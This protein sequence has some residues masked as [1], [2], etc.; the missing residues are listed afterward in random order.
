M[1]TAIARA[2]ERRA[3]L[4]RGGQRGALEV[5]GAGRHEIRQAADEISVVGRQRGFDDVD[6][7]GEVRGQHLHRDLPPTRR[8]LAQVDVR[9]GKAE[10][11]D[12]QIVIGLVEPTHDHEAWL[13][14]IEQRVDAGHALQCVARVEIGQLPDLAGRDG[15]DDLVGR[16]LDPHR[17]LV[18]GARAGDDD[19]G[20]IRRGSRLGCRNLLRV[21]GQRRCQ[22][23]SRAEQQRSA[24]RA[25]HGPLLSLG[26]RLTYGSLLLQGCDSRWAVS[27]F[28]L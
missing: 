20:T 28:S 27:G 18:G 6:M 25:N 22:N 19:V 15:I 7:R 4:D 1:V 21:S 16:P 5:E 11:V 17:L 9:R 26:K 14:L 12:Q 3:A 13:A 2:V 10:A 8:A 24:V 23:E